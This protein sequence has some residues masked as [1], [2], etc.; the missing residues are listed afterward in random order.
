MA[1]CEVSTRSLTRLHLHLTG[2]VPGVNILNSG[3]PGNGPTVQIRGIGSFSNSSPLYVVDGVF[4]DNIN[5][6]NNDDIQDM[7]ILK[8]AS[9]AAIYG[10]KAANG[11]VLITTKKGAK[12]QKAK[13][14]YNGYVGIQKATNVLKMANSAEYA[15][16]LTEANAEAYAPMLQASDRKSVV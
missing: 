11:V 13:V 3:G 1:E 15:Q 14:T 5:F 4:Y 12:N 7:S 9:A 6:L 16:M 2:K 10:V 8:D